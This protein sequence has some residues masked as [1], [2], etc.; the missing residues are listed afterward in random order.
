MKWK[1]RVDPAL[2][3]VIVTERDNVIPIGADIRKNRDVAEAIVGEH[4]NAV[5]KAQMRDYGY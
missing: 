1:W 5:W 3:V 4:N 2:G